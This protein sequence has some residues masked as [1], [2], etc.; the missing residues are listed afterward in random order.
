MM[1]P[2][3]SSSPLGERKGNYFLDAITETIKFPLEKRGKGGYKGFLCYFQ[4]QRTLVKASSQGGAE[5]LPGLSLWYE[6][7][8]ALASAKD[9]SSIFAHTMVFLAGALE[10]KNGLLGLLDGKRGKLF[11]EEASEPAL[12]RAKGN[13][14]KADEGTC[15]EVIRRGSPAVIADALAEPLVRGMDKEGPC[16]EF[17]CICAPL[18]WGDIP[19][20]LLLIDD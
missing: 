4:A 8:Q 17:P 1:S 2:S 7:N 5:G 19:L 11:V 18:R 14:C 15:G 12:Q 13:H 3:P 6:F 10:A 16:P 9:V 20:G